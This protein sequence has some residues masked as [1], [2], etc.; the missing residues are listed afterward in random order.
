MQ[1]QDPIYKIPAS[2]QWNF[3]V[4]RELP[5]ASTIEVQYVGRVG[6][7][8]ERTRNLNQL[9]AGTCPLGNCP[10]GVNV[11]Y[12]VPYKGY[13]QIQL[14]E[15]AARSKYDG[16]NVSW[17]RRFTRG[18]LFGVAY[19]LSKSYDNGSARRDIPFDSYNDKSFWGPSLYDTRHIA[20]INWVYELPYKKTGGVAGAVLGGWQIT[21]IT[22]FQ[23][24]SPFTIGTNTDYAGIGISSFQPW[25][26]N[27][28]TVYDRNFSNS[29]A[30][31][32]FWFRTKNSDGS[33]IFTAPAAGTFANQ[34]KNLY[35]GP[36]F[37]NW[38]LG[39]F[40]T[41][42]ITERHQI[43]FRAEAFNWLNHPNWGG[44]SGSP[45]FGS[46]P[47]PQGQPNGNPTSSTFGKVTTKDGRRNLQLSLKY[48]F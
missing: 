30:D 32:N 33:P 10:G 4:Q 3:T 46:P 44:Q 12:L 8:L 37:Q 34:T 7:W 48:N 19:T 41:F 35:Y 24:G 39:M 2:Y 23:S 22:Q 29:G 36:G 21:G 27:G 18:L 5:L 25:Q 17:N 20:V 47:G 28:P 13:N 9:P 40:K 42:R 26:V 45:G 11:N 14:A 16:L 31:G 6:L 38:N 1:T 15:N 43:T